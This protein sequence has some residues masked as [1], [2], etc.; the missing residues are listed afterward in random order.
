MDLSWTCLLVQFALS[1][2]SHFSATLKNTKNHHPHFE[3]EA[4]GPTEL[5]DPS[6]YQIRVI[7]SVLEVREGEGTYII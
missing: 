1:H 6:D 3:L 2:S 7:H 4:Y 5:P